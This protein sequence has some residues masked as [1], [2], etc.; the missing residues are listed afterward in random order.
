M[1]SY[2]I[3]LD[4]A[5]LMR[6]IPRGSALPMFQGLGQ[7]LRDTACFWPKE[8][9][10]FSHREQSGEARTKRLCDWILCIACMQVQRLWGMAIDGKRKAPTLQ[11]DYGWA[12]RMMRQVFVDVEVLWLSSG[13][14]VPSAIY[15][16]TED[17]KEERYE[18][19]NLISGPVHAYSDVALVTGTK[20]VVKIGKGTRNLFLGDDNKWFIEAK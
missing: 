12:F 16:K 14:Y 15:W 6:Y 9:L 20:Y 10:D 3:H 4:M 13:S 19:D 18:I 1:R 2:C 11:S 5:I 8:P 17:G 7:I